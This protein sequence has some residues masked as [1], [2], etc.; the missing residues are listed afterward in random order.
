MDKQELKRL[1]V[2][3]FEKLRE[4]I[5]N[6][7]KEKALELVDEID[8]TK[9]D[10][11][12]SYRQ[13]LDLMLTYIADNLG[14]EAL[15]E[16]HREN[17][18][19]AL[20]PRLGWIFD[21]ISIEEKVRKRAATWTHFHMTNLDAIEEDD[22]KFTFRIQCDSGGSIRMWPKYGKTREAHPWSHGEEGFSYYCAHCPIVLEMMAIDKKG[23]PAWVSEPQPGGKCIQYLYKDPRKVPD[24]Y[25]KRLGKEKKK[26]K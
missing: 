7:D 18:E 14:E 13:W 2:S 15:Y 3:V 21:P 10:F 11:D 12:E 5:K 24:K 20:W 26:A 17:G 25:Y 8:R 16:I 22:E 6:G 1:T 19:R 9:H 4:N 23:Y